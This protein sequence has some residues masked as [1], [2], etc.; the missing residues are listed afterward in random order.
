[1]TSFIAETIEAAAISAR[2]LPNSSPA[3]TEMSASGK[4]V[5]PT[6]SRERSRLTGTLIPNAEKNIPPAHPMISGF[7]IIFAA[8]LTHIAGILVPA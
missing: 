2:S 8:V 6:S 4:A 5:L 1:M 3:P 7:L